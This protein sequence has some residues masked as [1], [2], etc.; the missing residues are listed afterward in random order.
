[1][2]HIW[3]HLA[4]W[5]ARLLCFSVEKWCWNFLS[6]TLEGDLISKPTQITIK[7]FKTNIQI[8][9]WKKVSFNWLIV[10]TKWLWNVEK[11]QEKLQKRLLWLSLLL[12]CFLVT[13]NFLDSYENSSTQTRLV[14]VTLPKTFIGNRHYMKKQDAK[15]HHNPNLLDFKLWIAPKHSN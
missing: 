9:W 5:I 3:S 7:C 11:E 4:T 10:S 8:H 14:C 6:K 13:H 15:V 1:M 2:N 12:K